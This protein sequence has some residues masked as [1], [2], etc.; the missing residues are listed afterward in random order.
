MTAALDGFSNL[1]YSNVV[2]NV[3]RTTALE[4]QMS[5][6]IGETLTVTAESPLLDERK[7]S[8]GASVEKIE[9]DKIPSGRD[10]WTVLQ[11]VPG[12][13][14]DRIN[15]AGNESGQQSGVAGPG[16]DW[17]DTS[18]AVDGVVITDMGAV[19]ASPAYY[20]FDSFEEIQ[21]ATGGSDISQVT[22]GV[23]LNMVTKRGGNEWRGTARFIRADKSWQSGTGFNDSAL[24]ANQEPF[25]VGNQ[26]NRLD[27]WGADIGGPLLKDRLWIWANYSERQ[28][29]T[30]TLGGA[31]DDTEL[32]NYGT[33]LNAQ[34]A[35]NN[36]GVLYYALNEKI[37]LGRN[38][39][40]LRPQP[41]TWDQGGPGEIYKIE[42]THIF[43]SNF[44]LTG[45]YAFSESPFFLTPQGGFDVAVEVSWFSGMWNDTFLH[46]DTDRPAEQ[47]RLDADYFFSTGN[48]NHELKFGVGYRKSEITSASIWPG[49][50]IRTVGYTTYYPEY[51]DN[52]IFQV[53]QTLIG[54]AFSEYESAYI[55]DT[56]TVRNLTVN[57]GLRYDSQSG[58]NNDVFVAGIPGFETLPDGTPLFPDVDFQSAGEEFDWTDISPRVG[59]TYA[60]G[61]ERKTLLRAS[62]ARFSSQ[63]GQ[64]YIQAT[65]PTAYGNYRYAYFYYFD[66]NGDQNVTS[67]EIVDFADGP[68]W[69]NG[70]D[71]L[72]M[73]LNMIDPDFES[74]IT[75]ELILGVEHAFRPE[76]VVGA[77]VTWRN[78]HNIEELERLVDDGSGPR[79]HQRSDYVLDSVETVTYPDGSTFDVP[80]WTFRE[81]IEDLAGYL[82]TNGDRE[83]DFLGYSL[84]FNKRLSNRWMARGNFSW[85]EWEWSVPE[86]ERED[87]NLYWGGMFDDGGPVLLGGGTG[88]G[89][90]TNVWLS[91]GWT[92]SLSGLYQVAPDR[93]WGFNLGVALNG[94]EGFARPFYLHR[95]QQ[96]FVA[97]SGP[98]N[99]T[100]DLQ[101]TENSDDFKNPDVHLLDLRVE[102]EFTLDRFGFVL[103]A[104]LF[105]AFNEATV[106]QREDA[107]ERSTADEVQEIISPRIFRL[108]VRLI[109]N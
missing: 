38:A 6:A 98:F 13:K 76:L 63:L 43:S 85:S 25:E 21:V 53:A 49:N 22:A 7:I 15:V 102:K 70:Y 67:D 35:D 32:V 96:L 74:P 97:G 44:V 2:V 36:S 33:K 23:T 46:H 29:G 26:I 28:I 47:W 5:A 19:G 30:V 57:V 55:Q 18:W 106:L 104:E 10:P 34:L 3:G 48:V 56:L 41:T 78:K 108:S 51:Y 59:I 103:G 72:G 81:G 86:S 109:F 83:Q 95:Q 11:T 39:G 14:V 82:Y 94:R 8:A 100:V 40:P 90:K 91:P 88:S 27:E 17:F 84:T 87:P 52:N 58:A 65:Q 105:N 99:P 62:Y 20:N 101:A 66:A 89:S 54:D 24:G 4:L 37:K 12:V 75:D 42:D 93:S 9:M 77:N 69:T 64:A 16:S 50:G 107:V 31:T 45:L 80:L 92:Y 61:E 1:E 60:L 79:A 73:P 68:L 71:P